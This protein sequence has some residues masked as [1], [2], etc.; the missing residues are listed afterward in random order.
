MSPNFSYRMF[1]VTCFIDFFLPSNYTSYTDRIDVVDCKSFATAP[2]V[3]WMLSTIPNSSKFCLVM[4][5]VAPSTAQYNN[6]I[7]KIYNRLFAGTPPA[8][9]E[10]VGEIS[11]L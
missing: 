8:N 11:I 3:F 1:L 2:V 10:A 5:R 7:T 4:T 9:S 6:A